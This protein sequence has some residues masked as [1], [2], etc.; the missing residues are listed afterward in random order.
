LPVLLAV[1]EASLLISIIYRWNTFDI[2]RRRMSIH[3][4]MLEPQTPHSTLLGR[5]AK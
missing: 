2:L 3:K 1:D 5:L 4:L